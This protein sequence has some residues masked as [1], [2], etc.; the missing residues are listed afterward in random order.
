MLGAAMFDMTGDYWEF[1]K[2]FDTYTWLNFRL[3]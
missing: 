2:Q 3:S 1:D